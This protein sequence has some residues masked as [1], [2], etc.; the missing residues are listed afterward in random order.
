MVEYD[1]PAMDP[2]QHELQRVLPHINADTRQFVQRQGDLF[3][4]DAVRDPR[5]RGAVPLG[6]YRGLAQE[7]KKPLLKD[8][9]L[10]TCSSTP[11]FITSPASTG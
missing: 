3:K 1:I 6:A 9:L 5:R 7:L 10:A 8:H 2:R 11:A 4:D